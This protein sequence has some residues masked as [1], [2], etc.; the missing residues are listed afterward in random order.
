MQS[1]Q[2]L[3]SVFGCSKK[4]DKTKFLAHVLCLST[5]LHHLEQTGGKVF[6]DVNATKLQG[7]LLV[8]SL[9]RLKRH[10]TLL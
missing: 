9:F 2:E 6:F 1:F 3:R 4:A 7:S 5:H 8:Q 10:R